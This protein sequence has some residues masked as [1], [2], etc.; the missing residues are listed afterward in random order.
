MEYKCIIC[1]S[2]DWK[3]VD[4]FRYKAH[5]MSMCNKCSF[6]TYPEK[7]S[8]EQDVKKFYEHDYRQAPTVHNLFTSE[9]KLHYH[10]AFLEEIFAKWKQ[11][12]QSPVIVEI[13]AA[14]GL[15]LNY[16]KADFP[17][18]ELY[19]TEL[20][21]SFVRSAWHIYKTRLDEDF[22]DTKKYDLIMSYK[23]AEHMPDVIKQLGRYRQALKETGYLYISVPTWFK[24]MNDFGSTGFVME[25]YYDPNHVNIWDTAQ[26]EHLL[27]KCGFKI[28]KKNDT[29]YNDTYLCVAGEEC[30]EEYVGN[31]ELR[32]TQLKAIY[33]ASSAYEQGRYGDAIKAWPNFPSAWIAHYEMN[34]S[35]AHAQGF[36]HIWDT[37]LKPG[38]DACG[39]VH[40][41][42]Q[43]V[44]DIMM[45]YDKYQDAFEQ[46]KIW[47]NNHP[48]DGQALFNMA[49]CLR[50]LAMRSQ[51]EKEQKRLLNEA[52]KLTSYVEKNSLE[53]RYE[54]ITWIM[55][56]VSKIP[57]PFEKEKVQ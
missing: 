9:R 2:S 50:E 30:K 56:D 38:L 54:A 51:D 22:D 10:L 57:T 7:C 20:T 48:M 43:H 33:E 32:L 14:L 41:I 26:F 23:V 12:N 46:C 21:K 24:S 11:D 36:D 1:G 52:T 19:G 3:N 31:S 44:V 42:L 37:Y 8:K 15:F 35:R 16:L 29:Y 47:L 55:H 40:H 25:N 5:G 18:A 27:K 34:R 39:N 17:K 4:E 13:G 53:R 6:V 49:H 28:V 45:R